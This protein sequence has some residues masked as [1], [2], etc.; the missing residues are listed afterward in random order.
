MKTSCSPIG[1]RRRLKGLIRKTFGWDQ[2]F[3][4]NFHKKDWTEDRPSIM[5]LDGKPIGT[6]AIVEGD[7]YI[8]VGQFFILPEYQ[9]R[10]IG[11]VLLRR[12]LSQA[13]WGTLIVRLAF[14]KGNHAE[15][16]YR[17]NGFALV[18]QTET[19]SY[20]ERRPREISQ[21]P[22]LCDF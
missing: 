20:V 12:V 17:R 10:G 18:K 3:Q 13:D 22:S 19:H 9:N 14:L 11:S 21:Q 7:G 6:V 16:L 4:R 8:E 15:S 5:E 1:S 2:A